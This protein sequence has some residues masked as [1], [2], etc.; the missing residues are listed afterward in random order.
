MH[1]SA[2]LRMNWFIENYVAK[3]K[4]VKVLDVG[5]YN[6]N[7]CYKDLFQ[8][9]NNVEYFGLDVQAG[10]NVDIVTN[11]NYDW[12]NVEN[13]A[14]DY[15]ISGNTFEHIEYPW[16]TIK[17]IYQKLKFGGFAC[18]IAPNSS[19]EHRYPVDCYRYYADGFRAL[20]KWG[21]FHLINVSVAGIP[22]SSVSD[23]WNSIHNDVCM[24][25]LKSTTP[26]LPA[27]LDKFPKLKIE[28]RATVVQVVNRLITNAQA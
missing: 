15:V 27:E 1:Q 24:V 28:R 10:P 12:D 4:K 8:K 9:R 23:E 20:A 14:F 19:P 3:D 18:I 25:L 2:M 26:P 7:G 6:V 16:L 5:S 11:G 17:L 22:N 21:G 13:E